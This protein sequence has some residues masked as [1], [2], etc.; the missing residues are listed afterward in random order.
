MATNVKGDLY[1][2]LDGQ[3][4]EIK[5]QLRQKQGYPFNP[6][7]LKMALQA[8]IDGKFGGGV[9][10]GWQFPSVV[11]AA[12]LI[13]TGWSVV[14]DVN[15]SLYDVAKLK[16]TSYLKDGEMWIKSDEMRKRAVEMRGNLGLCDAKRLLANDGKLI[17][18][19][20]RKFFIPLP[21]TVLRDAVGG[22]YVPYLPFD[23]DRWFLY[24]S[25]LA[26]VWIG[27]CRLAS[28]E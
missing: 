21:G 4:G 3:L 13:P 5:R 10:S 23:G 8:I 25:W 24:F 15:P 26:R 1:Y 12:D 19:E 27:D 18:V 17:P 22:L 14:E 9:D 6:E 11:F 20:F 16:P 7:E 28:G 2:V